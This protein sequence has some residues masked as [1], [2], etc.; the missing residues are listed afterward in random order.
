MHSKVC[1]GSKTFLI[2]RKHFA[3]A[4]TRKNVYFFSADKE[5]YQQMYTIKNTR[6]KTYIVDFTIQYNTI[7]VYNTSLQYKS[8]NL[9]VKFPKFFQFISKT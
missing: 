4:T 1:L 9:T 3:S 5:P 8:T 7:Q 2:F 6:N